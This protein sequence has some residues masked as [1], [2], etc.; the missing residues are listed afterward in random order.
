MPSRARKQ[1]V[2]RRSVNPFTNR[3]TSI[4]FPGLDVH[5]DTIAVAVA[6]PGGEVRSL[7]TIPHRQ[8]WVR[9]LVAKL[10]PA[11]QL[12]ACYEG[13]PCGFALYWQVTS[14]GVACE[15][16]APTLAP[17]K[18]DDRAKTDHH[19]GLRLARGYR[20]GDLTA[21][22]VPDA[23]HEA[24]RDLVRAREDARQDQLRARHRLNQFL[25]R[26]GKRP[27]QEVKK[28]WSLK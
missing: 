25:L 8:E 4:R 5:A 20:A 3:H 16:A 18:A 24:L 11:R 22:P 26:H 2:G 15:V 12:R 1:A 14:L 23:G 6:E 9:N 17:V 21:V 19:D 13:G 7:G 27:P 28:D 10:G